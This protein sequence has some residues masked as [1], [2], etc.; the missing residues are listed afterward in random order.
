MRSNFCNEKRANHLTTLSPSP[1]T[2]EKW[3]K[4]A[5]FIHSKNN[6]INRWTQNAI[7]FVFASFCFILFYPNNFTSPHGKQLNSTD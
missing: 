3:A 6:I 1:F 4:R 7:A 2:A 5:Y